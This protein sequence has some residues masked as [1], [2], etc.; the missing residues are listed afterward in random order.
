MVEMIRK[1]KA[2]LMNNAEILNWVTKTKIIN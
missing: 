2:G 1:E